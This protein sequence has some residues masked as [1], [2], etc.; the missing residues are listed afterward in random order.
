MRLEHQITHPR[1]L[2]RATS[3]R[4]R[5]AGADRPSTK[6]ASGSR[7]V[8]A[9]VLDEDQRAQIARELRERR[10]G[11]EVGRQIFIGALEYQLCAFGSQLK[12]QVPRDEPREP[13]DPLERALRGVLTAARRLAG[14]L[15]ELPGGAR[16]EL[17]RGLG[18]EKPAAQDGEARRLAELGVEVERLAEAGGAAAE[19]QAARPQPEIPAELLARLAK[20]YAECFEKTPTADPEGAFQTTLGVVAEV[21]GI[22]L[23]PTPA[24]LARALGDG[25]AVADLQGGKRPNSKG[26]RTR[27]SRGAT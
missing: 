2:R 1:L 27:S 5:P 13:D 26:R 15:R 25:T 3:D 18:G 10:I 8:G 7:F 22:R 17:T 9:T 4:E 6:A 21:T 23:A 19:T 14:L 20:A 24:L 16:A 11:D 12:S